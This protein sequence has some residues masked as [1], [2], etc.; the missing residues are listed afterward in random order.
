[1]RN[2]IVTSICVDQK[3]E[4]AEIVYPMIGKISSESRRKIYWRL[5]TVFSCSSL[6]CNPDHRHIVYTN[7]E[8]DIFIN[9]VN[10]KKFLEEKGVEVIYLPFTNFCPPDD[11]ST[12]FKNAFYKLDVIKALG[13]LSQEDS[14]ILVDSDCLWVNCNNNIHNIIQGEKILLKVVHKNSDPYDRSYHNL[15]MSDMGE[16][17]LK[18][19]ED[20]PEAY[21]VWYGGEIIAGRNNN[22]K[23]IADELQR[24]FLLILSSSNKKD[25]IF[26]NGLKIFD[27]DEFLSSY[28]HNKKIVD[29]VEDDNF[30][31]RMWTMDDFNNIV[32]A[33]L[34][35]VI[36]HLPAEKSRGLYLLFKEVIKEDTGFW[37]VDITKF[38]HYLGDYVGVPERKFDRLIRYKLNKYIDS[39]RRLKS[40]LWNV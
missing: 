33:D 18:I 11:L 21:P 28:V 23:I 37:D 34:E 22:L 10:V 27:G 3:V 16:L 36:W 15:S 4:D 38:N 14:S 9:S 12:R 39:M 26:S 40:K 19:E 24:I 35:R 13:E 6:R 5:V 2:N 7:D 30:I 25:F 20:Y 31:K 8:N 29:I 32:Q 1:M 17:F